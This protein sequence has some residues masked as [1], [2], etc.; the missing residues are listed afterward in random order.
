MAEDRQ[1]ADIHEGASTKPAANDVEEDIAAKAKSAEDRKAAVALASLDATGGAGGDTSK[2]VDQEAM[3]KAMKNLKLGVN[4][5]A[6]K[7]V[8]V[9]AADVA[10]LVDQLEMTKIK[11]TDLLKQHEGDAV[12]ALR[13]YV[14]VA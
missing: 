8:K 2:N 14:S 3:S 9:D 12:K 5:M 10:L 1:P 6:A 7:K 4:G 13:A 11:A